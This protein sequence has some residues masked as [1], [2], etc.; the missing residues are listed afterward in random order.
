MT[1]WSYT[2]LTDVACTW[3]RIP[4]FERLTVQVVERAIRDE[5]RTGVRRRL[6]R[7]SGMR[8]IDEEVAGPSVDISQRL[9]ER[10]VSSNDM[11]RSSSVV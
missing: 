10:N 6:E 11:I 2:K 7:R 9:A 3:N 8:D 1:L 4:R 5:P